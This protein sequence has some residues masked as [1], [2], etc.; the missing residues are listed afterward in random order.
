MNHCD[1]CG[2]KYA[3]HGVDVVVGEIAGL[4]ARYGSRLR[5]PSGAADSREP[6]RRRPGPDT[7]SALEY[8]CHV[9]D[10]LL[11]QRERL[12]LTLV[13]DRPSFAPIYR[14]QRV[15]LARYNEEEPEQVAMQTELA[16]RLV[17]WAFA[18]LDGPDWDRFC[19]Y[20]FPEPAERSLL[21]LAQHTLHEGEH[22]L[23][24]ID[25]VVALT[26]R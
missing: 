5:V 17:S 4:G 7:W 9:R 20:N 8:A 18:G 12:F 2:F 16:A 22:H 19:I 3:D 1:E 11:A 15:V 25:R 13:E 26:T 10:V 24:D 23:R 6:L 21:W 14:E